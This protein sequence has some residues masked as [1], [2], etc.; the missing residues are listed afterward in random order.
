[1]RKTT[2]YLLAGLLTICSQ[3]AAA[4][5]AVA[6]D[7]CSPEL[8][9]QAD[10][11]LVAARDS[12]QSLAQHQRAF[13]ACDDG[14]LAAGYSDGVTRLFAQRWDEFDTFAT[15]AGSDPAFARWAVGHIDASASSGDLQKI[16]RNAGR[17]GDVSAQGLC[18]KVRRAASVALVELE[19]ALR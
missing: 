4:S 11:S 3:A 14:A 8:S 1:M 18:R 5:S 7:S 16:L 6:R 19:N 9:R 13:K 12:W 2:L 10:A 17:C 15:I